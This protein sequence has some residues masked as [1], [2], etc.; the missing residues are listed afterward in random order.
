MTPLGAVSTTGL[1]PFACDGKRCSSRSVA[2]WLSLPGS[3]RLSFTFGP[4]LRAHTAS[5]AKISS[6]APMTIQ[7]RRTQSLARW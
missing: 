2:C 3:V 4:A 7:R 5:T 6:H 1:V